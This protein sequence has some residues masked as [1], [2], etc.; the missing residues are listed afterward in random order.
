MEGI[1]EQSH[2]IPG[3]LSCD[4]PA[5]GGDR[6]PVTP[7]QKLI[8]LLPASSITLLP[9]HG[10]QEQATILSEASMDAQTTGDSVR[11][12]PGKRRTRPRH[13]LVG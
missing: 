4:V 10:T 13:N 3:K 1:T 9:S 12:H 7:A 2:G 8:E 11:R 6:H 5:P